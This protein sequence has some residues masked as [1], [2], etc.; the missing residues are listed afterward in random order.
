MTKRAGSILACVRKSV[1]SKTREVIIFL[2][3]NLVRLHLEYHVQ[4]WTSRYKK[5]I[6][7]LVHILRR[8]MKLLR[9]LEH[10]SREDHWDC[11]VWRRLRG[12]ITTVWKEVV[13]R[14]LGV[15]GRGEEALL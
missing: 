13:V 3:S 2:Y 14:W 1:V 10:K 5:V 12:D 11:L 6:E 15:G 7:I 4:F 9:G 8:I